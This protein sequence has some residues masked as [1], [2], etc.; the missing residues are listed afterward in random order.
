MRKNMLMISLIC[1]ILFVA[2]F[3]AGSSSGPPDGR[4]GAPG[5]SDCTVGCHNTYALNSGDGSLSIDNVPAQY[6]PEQIYSLSVTISDP[7]QEKWGFELTV[8][9]DSNNKAGGLIVT[10]STNTQLS[11]STTRDY[12]KHTS[13]GTF[14]GA[15]NGPVTWTFNW[16]APEPGTGTVT[17]Y[18]AGNAANSA[19]GNKFDYIYTTSVSSNDVNDN[20]TVNIIPVCSISSPSSGVKLS[21]AATISG[22]SSDSDGTIEMVEVRIDSGSWKEAVGTTS[23]SYELDTTSISNGAHTIYARAYDGSDHSSLASVNI[24]VDNQADTNG[25][26]EEED[27]SF[28]IM[29]LIIVIILVV[30]I[31]AVLLRK[32]K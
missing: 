31:A 3:A 25:D 28:L 14:D 9:D 17:F 30:V 7:G 13:A 8:L 23:W 19:G 29:I 24:E 18:A 1:A 12:I 22:T 6:N 11:S 15:S 27:S 16:L 4:T 10:D 26:S 5:E 32:R 2:I 20:G 21:G